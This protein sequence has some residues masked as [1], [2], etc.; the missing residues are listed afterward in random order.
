MN[1]SN[2]VMRVAVVLAVLVFLSGAA[3]ARATLVV[4]CSD[5]AGKPLKKVEVSLQLL[6]TRELLETIRSDGKGRARFKKLTGG[7]YRIW[8]R[9]DGFQPVYR[10]FLNLEEGSERSVDLRFEPGDSSQLLYFEDSASLKKAQQLYVEGAQALLGRQIDQAQEKLLAARKLNPSDPYI[11]KYLGIVFLNRRNWKEARENLEKAVELL[12]MLGS[13]R[14]DEERIQIQQRRQSL[15]QLAAEIPLMQVEDQVEQAV[16]AREY[17][18]VLDLISKLLELNPEKGGYHYNLALAYLHS[19]R[20]DE[21]H[22]LKLG[23]LIDD[24]EKNAE[25]AKAR[26]QPDEPSIE[27]E[28]AELYLQAERDAQAIDAFRSFYLHSGENPDQNL[29]KKAKES[30]RKGNKALAILIYESIIRVS[31]DFPEAYFQ[32][33]MQRYFDN[34]Y[35]EAKK[36]LR[37]YQKIGQDP[38]N[39]QNVEATLVVMSRAE[40]Q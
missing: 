18:Q 24:H 26:E 38:G 28:L 23:A 40:G 31:P 39:L 35:E 8:A 9:R 14:T 1:K 2:Q 33:G 25:V 15:E 3:L 29:V 17:P 11:F 22:K 19:D 5:S 34:Q 21:A 37:Q 10:E 16:Q 36:L 4:L 13:F 32:L 7:Y 27:K 30:V 12:E 6:E 20:I